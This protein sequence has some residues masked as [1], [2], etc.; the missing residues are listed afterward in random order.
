VSDGRLIVIAGPSGVGKGTVVK[1]L[2]A[3]DPRLVLS[4]SATTR[5]RRPDEVNQVDYLFVDDEAFDRMDAAGELLERAEVFRGHRYGTPRP[6]VESQRAEGRDV[7]LEID[8]EGAAQIRAQAPD[9]LL[10]LLVPPSM[11]ALEARLRGRATETEGSIA[12]RLR[13]AGWELDQRS[14]FDHTVEND[15]IDEAVDEVAAIIEAS[16]T[17]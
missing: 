6:F 4:V 7:V 10:I 16:R 9:A 11:D 13:K 15:A 3:R 12:E 17:L 14:W 5:T 1:G 2:L 8:V